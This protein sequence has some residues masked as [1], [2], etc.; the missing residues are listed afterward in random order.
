MLISQ[1]AVQRKLCQPSSSVAGSTTSLQIKSLLCSSV[2][3][4]VYLLAT[5]TSLILINWRKSEGRNFHAGSV[6]VLSPALQGQKTHMEFGS[7][8]LECNQGAPQQTSLGILRC[9]H[10]KF[11]TPPLPFNSNCAQQQDHTKLISKQHSFHSCMCVGSKKCSWAL[12]SLKKC[13]Y[14]FE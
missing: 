4:D 13:A 14:K 12:E 8:H 2:L 6:A 3:R 1:T 9:S 10:I 11:G 5:L 7:K